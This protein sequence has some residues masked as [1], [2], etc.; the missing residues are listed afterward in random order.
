M[1]KLILAA[2]LVLMPGA[3][4]A[5]APAPSVAPTAAAP[6]RPPLPLADQDADPALWVVRDA[7]TIIYLF[8]TIHMLDGRSWFNDEVKAAFDA[9]DELVMEAILPE[10]PM[11]LL[12]MIMRYAVDQS[13]TPL[14]SRLT[15]QE[16]A[17][18][19][20]LTAS[21]GIPPAMFDRF[22]PWF[23]SMMLSATA[24]QRAGID[25]ANGPETVLTQAA[26]ARRIPIRELEG[27]EWQIQMFDNMP[28]VFQLASL[29]ASLREAEESDRVLGPLIAAWSRGDDAAIGQALEDPRENTTLRRVMLSNRNANWA[30][31]I[32]D[33]LARPG[34]LFIAVGA[35]HLAGRDSVQAALR[36]RGIES[37]RVPH[38]VAR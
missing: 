1:K 10:D 21:L 2:A 28:P 13:G 31:W 7:D 5:Q 35:A 34:T 23:A 37:E 6:A 33:R 12:P 27:F 15:A 16:N 26:N 25:A 3:A 11:S 38:V 8:G 29:R 18:L 20:R 24:A 36:A 9:S 19:A 30:N 4:A 17:Q 14:S 32:R 22:E